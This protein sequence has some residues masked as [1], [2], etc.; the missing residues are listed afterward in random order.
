M[1]MAAW[2]FDVIMIVLYYGTVLYLDVHSIYNLLPYTVVR[3][4]VPQVLSAPSFSQ[5][6]EGGREHKFTRPLFRFVNTLH[7]AA[8]RTGCVTIEEDV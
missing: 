7:V 6:L 4:N 5:L 2:H 3:N 1:S 8:I